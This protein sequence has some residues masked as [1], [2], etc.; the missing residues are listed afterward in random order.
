MKWNVYGYSD[1]T[2]KQNSN[3]DFYLMDEEF[4]LYILCDATQDAT[5]KQKVSEF[6]ARTVRDLIVQNKEYLLNYRNDKSSKNRSI[7]AGLVQKTIQAAHQSLLTSFQSNENSTVKA[8]TMFECLL[9]LEDYAILSHVGNSRI[10]LFRENEMH[11]LTKDYHDRAVGALTSVQIDSLQVELNAGDSFLMC[12]SSFSENFS[13]DEMKSHLASEAQAIPLQVEKSLKMKN[14]KE[15][16]S[17][18]VLKSEGEK[19]TSENVLN[20]VKKTELMK[21]INIFRFMTYQ[22]MM[23]V[24]SVASLKPFKKGDYLFREGEKSDELFIIAEGEVEVL[25]G[26]VQIVK[27]GRGDVFGEMGLFENVPR[28]ATIKALSSG[29]SLV[30]KR[31]ELL[32]L[33]RQDSPIC[34]KLLWALNTELN[35]R[36]RKATVSTAAHKLNHEEDEADMVV[37]MDE[38]PFSIE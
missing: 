36:L 8:F 10:Y 28:S 13:E 7:L 34:V 4:G 14:C 22:E 3:V 12:S 29:A 20:I 25:K 35:Q 2:V 24:L 21:E 9:I 37:E 6:C 1:S 27:R 16:T 19:K 5:F 32:T 18:I 26:E 23:K 38:V 31:S 15:L 30:F 11:L 17:F 33:L